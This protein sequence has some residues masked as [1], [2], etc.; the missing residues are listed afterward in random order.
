[1]DLE[2]NALQSTVF[3]PAGGESAGE[4]D[5]LLTPLTVCFG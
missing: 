4:L 5:F 3:A 1:M 2:F